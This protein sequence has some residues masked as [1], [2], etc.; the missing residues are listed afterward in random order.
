M[1]LLIHHLLQEK[2][3]KSHGKA[4]QIIHCVNYYPYFMCIYFPEMKKDCG[5]VTADP[6]ASDV[7]V[8][9]MS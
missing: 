7:E 4:A 3:K 5:H 8:E 6:L 1:L 2:L 9:T